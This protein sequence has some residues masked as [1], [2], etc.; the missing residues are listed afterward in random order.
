MKRIGIIL[1]SALMLQ[2]LWHAAMP[3]EGAKAQALRSPPALIA[4][5][6]A[7]LDESIMASRF[8]M[9]YLQSFDIQ[10][11]IIM[12]YRDLDY[13]I[14]QKWLEA[15][16]DLDTRDKYPLFAAT[17]FYAG[18]KD[19]RKTRSML[20]FISREFSID[21]EE[22]WPWMASGAL[23]AKYELHD[24]PLAL[25]YSESLRKDATGAPSW[26]RE[27]SIFTLE[28][29]NRL[30]A[31]KIVLGGLLV[32]G[33]IKDPNELAFLKGRLDRIGGFYGR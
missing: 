5:R 30:D 23:I 33:R 4:L 21:P 7:S 31:A 22:R 28:D 16:L 10:P 14:V 17:Y 9:L 25:E 6:L 32:D 3:R 29:M 12:P 24:L 8:M 2:L 15:S 26:V 18:V 13:G 1:V 27:M 19:E 11:G 20:D